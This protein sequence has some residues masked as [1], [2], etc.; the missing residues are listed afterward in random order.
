MPVIARSDPIELKLESPPVEA[1]LAPA[2]LVT[3]SNVLERHRQFIGKI[4]A[5]PTCFARDALPGFSEDEFTL[6]LGIAKID[7]YVTEA[8]TGLYCSKAAIEK[9]SKSL[10]RL[11]V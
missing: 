3:P 5:A 8:G 11:T 6:H 7:K 4:D 1:P 9:L 10:E 2:Q